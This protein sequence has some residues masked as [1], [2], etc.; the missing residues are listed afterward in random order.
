VG[1]LFRA[2]KWSMHLN[3]VMVGGAFDDPAAFAAFLGPKLEAAANLSA[4]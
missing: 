1:N 3:L 2:R 4:D